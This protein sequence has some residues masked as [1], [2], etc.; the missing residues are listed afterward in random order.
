MSKTS[1]IP[2]A[3]GASLIGHA[4]LFRDDRLALFQS[5][6]DTGELSSVRLLHRVVVFANTPRAAHELL[7]SQAK[8]FEKSPGIRLLLFYLAGEGL[9]TSEGEL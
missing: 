7:V 1:T 8:R 9:F 3:P 4:Q 2:E 5:L 6:A